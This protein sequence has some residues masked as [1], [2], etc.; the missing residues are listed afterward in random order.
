MFYLVRLHQTW[1]E[2]AGS[3]GVCKNSCN[4]CSQYIKCA[5]HKF[6]CQRDAR[7]ATVTR[8][9]KHSYVDIWHKAKTE[10]KTRKKEKEREKQRDWQTHCLLHWTGV[11]LLRQP[12]SLD[13][14]LEQR[15]ELLQRI[16][17]SVHIWGQLIWRYNQLL[18]CLLHTTFPI[19]CSGL[20]GWHLIRE[21]RAPD[22]RQLCSSWHVFGAAYWFGFMDVHGTCVVLI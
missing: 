21:H 22:Y 7:N 18:R 3:T 5:V 9:K 13:W 2:P 6:R 4:H 16:W 12:A 14:Y 8:N 19:P 11:P 15:V 20:S 17:C 10:R 1:S